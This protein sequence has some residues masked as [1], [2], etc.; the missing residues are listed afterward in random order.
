ME[1]VPGEA[2][3][4]EF[5]FKVQ[6]THP[7]IHPFICQSILLPG[8]RHRRR[9]L[10][11]D[12]HRRHGWFPS[13]GRPLACP[14]ILND[15][16]LVFSH[17]VSRLSWILYLSLSYQQWST[18]LQRYLLLP[19]TNSC[20]LQYSI[21]KSHSQ[22][23]NLAYCVMNKLFFMETAVHKIPCF[24][25]TVCHLRLQPPGQSS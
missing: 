18:T 6:S 22:L 15:C 14:G 13:H 21:V 11:V 2:V 9:S 16:S 23:V 10:Q 25:I 5:S 1:G 17:E 19:L 20:I 7:S 3:M 4:G 8:T 12:L 24:I